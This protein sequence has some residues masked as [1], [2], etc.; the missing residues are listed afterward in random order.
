[1]VKAAVSLVLVLAVLSAQADKVDLA[2]ANVTVI[3]AVSGERPGQT[4]LINGDRIVGI[5]VSD[6]VQAETT[7]D[8]T[9]KF[10][11]PGLW[12]MHV[13]IIYEPRLTDLMPT[14]FL[15]YGITSVRDTGALLHEITP[16]VKRWEAMGANAPDLYFSGPLLD[17]SLVVYDGEGRTEIGV[18]T[19]T[20][21]M[22]V[23]RVAELK[24]AGADFIKIY[25]LVSPAVF[26]ALVE[27]AGEAGLPIAAHVP[28]SMRAETAGPNVGSM[29]HLRNIEIACANNAD[30]LYEERTLTLGDPGD[31]NGYALRSHLHATQRPV[32]LKTADASSAACIEVIRSLRETIQVPTVRMN[33]IVKYSPAKRD[34]WTTHLASLPEE[35]ANEWEHTANFF[36]LNSSELGMLMSEWSMNLIAEMNRQGVPI[37]AGTD[38]PIAQ[39]IP[40][41]SLHTEMERLVDSGMTNREALYAAT[42]RPAEFFGLEG[43]M[44]QI[45]PGMTA[46]LVLLRS[47]P[48][49]DIRHTRHI[50]AVISN[51]VKVR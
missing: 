38:T 25:E 7:I 2:I 37:G 40:G 6:N 18:S 9:G 4:V 16:E 36:V 8:G 19:P 44:G 1:M 42:V 27:A 30:D 14:L 23:Q 20:E 28:L 50:E 43:R 5:A 31:R 11:I 3:D 34:D 26:A 49:Q 46:D 35:V 41:Y 47:N 15:D 21:Q 48:L 51:G 33:S 24:A 29:E 22:A 10:L 45:S 39:S 17:G 12:D 13:H 32:A